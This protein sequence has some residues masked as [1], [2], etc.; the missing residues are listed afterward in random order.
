MLEE[1][2]AEVLE[3]A[4]GG[5]ADAFAALWEATAPMVLRYLRVRAGQHAEDVASLTWVH[6]VDSLHRFEGDEPGFRRWV[7]TIARNSH[8]DLLRRL[9]RRPEHAVADISEIV[10]QPLS[11]D[12]AEIAGEREATRRALALVATLPPDQAELVMLRVVVGL[13]VAEVAALTGRSPGSVRVAVHR[14]LKRLRD[15]LGADTPHVTDADR[16]TFSR[17]DV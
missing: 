2:F 1:R 14:A 12:P 17:R 4:Q 9:G 13:D 10:G 5:D 15:T 16:M 8:V 6:V 11:P 7:V 3:A